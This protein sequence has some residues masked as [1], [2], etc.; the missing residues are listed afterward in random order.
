MLCEK[1]VPG[2]MEQI[3]EKDDSKVIECSDILQQIK[4]S[5]F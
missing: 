5:V 4:C 1:L 3:H 2:H